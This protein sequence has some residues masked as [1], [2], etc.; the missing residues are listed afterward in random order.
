MFQQII[1]FFQEAYQE[2][3]LSTWLTRQQVLAST[4]VVISLTVVVAIYVGLID[5]VLLRAVG[6]FFRIG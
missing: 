5:W 1:R 6:I 2:L 4:I 3:K